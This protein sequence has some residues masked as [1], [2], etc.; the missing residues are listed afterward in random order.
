MKKLKILLALMLSIG[1]LGCQQTS[2]SKHGMNVS[3]AGNE[4]TL[5]NLPAY[6]EKAYIIINDNVP[7]FDEKYKNTTAFENYSELD[8]LG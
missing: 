1:L 4:V 3:N 5:E 8:E 7:T 6:K 2:P